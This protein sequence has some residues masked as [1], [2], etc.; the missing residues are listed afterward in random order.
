MDHVS[1]TILQLA[2]Q[3]TKQFPEEEQADSVEFF[4]FLVDMLHN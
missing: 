3:D 2:M 4:V 1:P